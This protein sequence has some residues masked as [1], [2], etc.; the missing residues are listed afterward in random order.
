MKKFN[1][2]GNHVGIFAGLFGALLSINALAEDIK[3]SKKNIY[4]KEYK[5]SKD[6]RQLIKKSRRNQITDLR[7]KKSH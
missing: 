4:N 3:L 6:T 7:Y 1:Y 5:P 2:Y